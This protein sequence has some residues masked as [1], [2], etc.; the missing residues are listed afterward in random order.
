MESSQEASH[1]A[2]FQIGFSVSRLT[3]SFCAPQPPV[4]Y[5][6]PERIMVYM[7]ADMSHVC[8]HWDLFSRTI[9]RMSGSTSQHPER[10]L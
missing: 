3:F 5:T 4:L 7:S 10:T 6:L 9:E 8:A 2:T 1:P